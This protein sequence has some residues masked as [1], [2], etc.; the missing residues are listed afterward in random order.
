M[1]PIEI[2][3]QNSKM[4]SFYILCLEEDEAKAIRILNK[5]ITESIKEMEI[6][7]SILKINSKKQPIIIIEENPNG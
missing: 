7:I 1:K 2:E 4:V 3:N 5:K 6:D